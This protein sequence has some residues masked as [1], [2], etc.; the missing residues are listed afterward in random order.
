[1]VLYKINDNEIKK[2]KRTTFANENVKERNDLQEMLKKQIDIISPE[3]LIVAEEFCEWEDS[4]RRI[5]LL[6]IDKAANLVVIELKRTEDG[7]HMELQAIRYASMISNLLKFDDLVK[8]YEEYLNINNILEDAQSHL[9]DFLGWEEPQEEEFAQKIKIVL[10]SADFSK[11]LT[12]SVMWLNDF[13]LDIR[14]VRLHPYTDNGETYLDV[15]TV[16]P[17]PEIEDFQKRERN[18]KQKE[19]ESRSHNRD[20]TKF[21]LNIAGETLKNLSKRWMMFHAVSKTIQSGVHPE[22]LS[23]VFP[24]RKFKVFEGTLNSKQV[25]NCLMENDKDGVIPRANRFFN[26]ETEFFLVDGKTYVLSN[27]WGKSALEY[28]EKLQKM[29]PTLQISIKNSAN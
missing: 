4:K 15:Q 21:D 8:I 20:F 23:K 17:L 27:Q 24:S 7:G 10:A 14:C 2:I 28:I 12:S 1:M 3:T 5:D 22:E 19:R 6:G 25:Y 9:L 11:E 26:K 13:Q 29:Y 16:I 18:K